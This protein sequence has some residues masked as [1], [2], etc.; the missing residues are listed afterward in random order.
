VVIDNAIVQDCVSTSAAPVVSLLRQGDS[1]F[2]ITN[3]V[4]QNLY[5]TG[6][7]PAISIQ[8][9]GPSSKCAT[10]FIFCFTSLLTSTQI[11]W[12]RA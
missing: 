2:T 12:V 9:T 4:F 6:A 10:L 5:G 11:C 1:G 8:A 7:M 3:S